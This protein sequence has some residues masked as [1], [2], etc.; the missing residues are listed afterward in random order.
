MVHQPKDDGSLDVTN[1]PSDFTSVGMSTP[2]TPNRNAQT[3]IDAYMTKVRELVALD[4]YCFERHE[5][6]GYE[7]RKMKND[8]WCILDNGEPIVIVHLADEGLA[9]MICD[10]AVTEIDP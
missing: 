1:P 4:N 9:Q 2:N 5:R 8:L 10:M 3:W 7:V 6:M